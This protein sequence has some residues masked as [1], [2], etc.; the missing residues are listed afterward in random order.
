MNVE[1]EIAAIYAE[2]P[3]MKCKGLCQECCGPIGM[4]K[5]EFSRVRQ[6]FTGPINAVP[7]PLSMSS[8]QELGRALVIDCHTCPML[9][10]GRCTVY[11]LRPLI[12]RIWG[13]VQSMR[14]AHGCTPKRWLSPRESYKLLSRMRALSSKIERTNTEV[15]DVAKRA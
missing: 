10:D 8:G 13:T 6:R 12:C 5:L 11:D 9:K 7:M 14:C 2:V 3:E 4:T 1:K 15:A